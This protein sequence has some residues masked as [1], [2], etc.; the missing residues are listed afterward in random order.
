MVSLFFAVFSL[1]AFLFLPGDAKTGVT[2]FSA[3]K[4][5][6]GYFHAVMREIIANR[7]MRKFMLSYLIYEDGVITVIVFSS[8]F[9]STTLGSARRS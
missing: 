1:P 5:G 8:I 7:D 2:V 9:A 3:A 6:W 4:K